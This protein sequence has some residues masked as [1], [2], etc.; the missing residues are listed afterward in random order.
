[1]VTA[2]EDALP[3]AGLP[4]SSP[5]GDRVTPLG[6]GP[7][8]EN[9][10]ASA[11]I[12]ERTGSEEAVTLRRGDPP[13]PTPSP[14]LSPSGMSSTASSPFRPPSRRSPGPT[15]W[16]TRA[17]GSLPPGFVGVP[18]DASADRRWEEP[19]AR[20]GRS[21][22]GL[23]VG[24]ARI[25]LATSALSVLRSNRLSYSPRGRLRLHQP[26]G[27]LSPSRHLRPARGGPRTTGS[28]WP[29]GRRPPT[30]G[31]PHPGRIR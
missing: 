7:L 17:L 13:A 19:A 12:L 3:V 30:R 15:P 26:R 27:A 24:L 25:E 5:L 22:L 14:T 29:R 18:T 4:E 10:G 16:V 31:R 8:S 2:Y 6:R 20:G 28:Q 1:M 9:A 23:G 21:E 11:A